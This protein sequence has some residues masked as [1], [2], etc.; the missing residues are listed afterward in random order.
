MRERGLLATEY[1]DSVQEDGQWR[2]ERYLDQLDV[3]PFTDG[4]NS[5]A[6]K[7]R[8]SLDKWRVSLSTVGEEDR[9]GSAR[10]DLI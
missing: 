1:G 9:R 6:L 4:S 5:P 8:C 7:L 3:I 10:T 2:R